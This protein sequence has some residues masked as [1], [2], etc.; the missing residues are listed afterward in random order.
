MDLQPVQDGTYQCPQCRNPFH[1]QQCVMAN[2][3]AILM[4]S[5]I[6]QC[7]ACGMKM[8]I[9]SLRSHSD[10]C[11]MGNQMDFKFRP[12]VETSQPVPQPGPNQS[13]FR[14]PYCQHPNLDCKGMVEHCNSQ[15]QRDRRPVVCPICASMPWGD[16]NMTSS[17][18]MSHLNACHNF[19]YETYVDYAQDDDAMLNAAIQASLQQQ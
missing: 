15:H 9:Q 8:P 4:S 12:V 2:D 7:K 14:C 3:I 17:N 11:N 1:P 6:S 13:T 5:T 19:E 18:F 16:P 10:S